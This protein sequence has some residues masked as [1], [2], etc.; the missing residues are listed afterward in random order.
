MTEEA[1]RFKNN[2]ARIAKRTSL[3]EEEDRNGICCC[4]TLLDLVGCVMVIVV[5]GRGGI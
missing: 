4:L 5:A 1:F 2:N 3:T